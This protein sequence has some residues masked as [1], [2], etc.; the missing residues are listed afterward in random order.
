MESALEHKQLTSYKKEISFYAK[1]NF[2]ESSSPVQDTQSKKLC[3]NEI[4]V[5]QFVI[6]IEKL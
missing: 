2:L 3:L 1:D 5:L 4:I 6:K